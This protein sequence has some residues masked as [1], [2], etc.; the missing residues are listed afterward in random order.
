L[1]QSIGRPLDSNIK[2]YSIALSK[3]CLW[4]WKI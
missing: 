3:N 2:S 1:K 4:T